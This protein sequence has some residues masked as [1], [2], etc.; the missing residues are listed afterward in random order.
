VLTWVLIPI[1]EALVIVFGLALAEAIGWITIAKPWTANLR[2]R[3]LAPILLVVIAANAAWFG[4]VK[5]KSSQAD[6]A[7]VSTYCH[8]ASASAAQERGCETHVTAAQINRLNTP[9]ATRAQNLIQQA[10]CQGDPNS[11]DC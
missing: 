7:L 9:A 8:I 10:A 6:G 1:V 2:P 4:Y 11:A 3:Q 5:L